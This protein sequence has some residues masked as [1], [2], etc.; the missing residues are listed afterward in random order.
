MLSKSTRKRIKERKTLKHSNPSQ[1][2]KR[3]KEQS[4]QAIVDLALI[5]EN[6]EEELLEEIFVNDKF[7][8]LLRAI[9]KPKSKGAF[10]ITELLANLATQKLMLELPNEMVNSLGADIGKTWTYAQ[11]L[12]KYHDKPLVKQPKK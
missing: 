3:I 6:L 12:R 2:L 8:A 7:V 9:L 10:Q 11:L 1:F 4:L 5:A